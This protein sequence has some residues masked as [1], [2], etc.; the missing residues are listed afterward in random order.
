MMHFCTYFDSNYLHRGIAL[1]RSMEGTGEPFTLWILCFDDTT[2]EIL[3]ALKLSHAKLIRQHDF[4][5]GDTELLVAKEN[6]SR[7]EYYW[8]CTPS[9]VLYILK[10][11]S[12]VRV[13]TY[14][15]ADIYFFSSPVMI[16][17]ILGQGSILIV[18]HDYSPQFVSHEGA[19]KY[20]VGVVTFRADTN[21]L[22]CLRWWRDRCIEWCYWRHEDGKIGDQAYLND[23][24]ER[25]EGVV[26]SCNIGLNAAPWNV[27]KYELTLDGQGKVRIADRPLVCYHFH[28][29]RFC[30][31]SLVFLIGWD[32]TLSPICLSSVYLPYLNRLLDVEREL[33]DYGFDVSMPR[34]GIPWRYVTAR[35]LKRQPVRNFIWLR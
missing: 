20:N 6:R 9:L 19:G 4:E 12:D 33:K 21:G 31:S 16:P 24:P 7:V 30:T 26:A 22:R 15:D 10:F 11:Q 5:A 32:V 14:V 8:T 35:I 27:S 17:E 2:Y 13:I 3:T 1:Y 25:F 34:S 23:W 18:P 28:A 29:C